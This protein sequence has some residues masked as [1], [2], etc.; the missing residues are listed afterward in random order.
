MG[1]AGIISE[2]DVRGIRSKQSAGAAV[3]MVVGLVLLVLGAGGASAQAAGTFAI[4]PTSG[5]PGV[6]VMA[7][8]VTPCPAAPAGAVADPNFEGTFVAVDIASADGQFG[9]GDFADLPDSGGPWTFAVD[10]GGETLPAGAYTASAECGY[11]IDGTDTSLLTYADLPFQV[12]PAGTASC[13]AA[14]TTTAAPTTTTTTAA[15]TT[16]AAVTTTTKAV[17]T[18]TKAKATLAKTG[19]DLDLT[20]QIGLVVFALGLVFLG[21]SMVRDARTP[22][23]PL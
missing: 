20:T 11:T 6:V 5:P 8:G 14:T 4:S 2:A 10:S 3:T 22:R 18:T 12:C 19:H 9:F 7:S 1:L 16:T 15:P 21:Q 23:T 13:A 17:T